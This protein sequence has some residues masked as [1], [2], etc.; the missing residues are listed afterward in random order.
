MISLSQ[1]DDCAGSQVLEST[2]VT[3]DER[4]NNPFEAAVLAEQKVKVREAIDKLPRRQ[5]ATLLLAYYQEMT[6][7]EVAETLGCSIGTVKTQM[8]RALRR[9]AMLLPE[10]EGG[11]E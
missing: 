6:Y 5:R 1:N 11:M 10:I 2:A 8:Y 7:S 9:L 4:S 3:S